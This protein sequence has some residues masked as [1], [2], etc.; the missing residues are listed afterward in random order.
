MPVNVENSLP[1]NFFVR[2]IVKIKKNYGIHLDQCV[3][4]VIALKNSFKNF[5]VL[6]KLSAGV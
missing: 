3:P 4:N 5:P 1:K 2:V 6:E